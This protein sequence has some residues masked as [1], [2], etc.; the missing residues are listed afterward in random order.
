MRSSDDHFLRKVPCFS[1]MSEDDVTDLSVVLNTKRYGVGK[2]I[3]KEGAQ[4]DHV[5]FITII[6]RGEAEVFKKVSRGNPPKLLRLGKLGPGQFITPRAVLQEG[7][8]Q[9]LCYGVTVKTTSMVEL[10]HLSKH[11]LL[12]RGEEA[13]RRMQFALPKYPSYSEA[14]KRF[15]RE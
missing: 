13:L 11:D 1:K 12:H 7:A 5:Q 8:G 6:R 14:K 3:F 2:Y 10:V 9:H 15:K 4:V